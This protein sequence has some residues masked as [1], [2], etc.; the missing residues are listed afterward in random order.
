M[1]KLFRLMIA[2]LFAMSL[3]VGCGD[4]GGA[5]EPEA[6]FTAGSEDFGTEGDDLGGEAFGDEEAGDEAAEDEGL[7]DF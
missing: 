5:E 7:D 2:G 6:D 3:A 4:E 1:K